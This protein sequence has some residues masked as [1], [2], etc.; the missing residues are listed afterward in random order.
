MSLS[1]A[2]VDVLTSGVPPIP[3]ERYLPWTDLSTD[4]QSQ[5]QSVLSY[6]VR[7]W[8]NPGKNNIEEVAY[9]DLCL[10]TS[11]VAGSSC[12]AVDLLEGIGFTS[13]DTW[14]CWI[15][16]YE[17]FTWDE[18]V[19]MNIAQYY[20]VL[21]W[22]SA[23]WGSENEL[24]HP[25]SELKS[26]DDLS[27]QEQV[28]AANLCF[29]Q[30]LWDEESFS[31]Y[32]VNA[33][34]FE[35]SYTS[36]PTTSPTEDILGPVIDEAMLSYPYK[37]FI[38]FENLDTAT[39]ELVLSLGYSIN[40]WDRPGKYKIET[41]PFDKVCK[42]QEQCDA[43]K[44]LGFTEDS[45]NCWMGHYLEFDWE[46]LVL[47]GKAQYWEVLGWTAT[48]WQL[49]DEDLSQWPLTMSLPYEQLSYD[50][51]VAAANLCYIEP[52]W[53][54]DKLTKWASDYQEISE[55]EI[56][57]EIEAP[58][59]FPTPAPGARGPRTGRGVRGRTSLAAQLGIGGAGATSKGLVN[60]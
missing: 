4:L 42:S 36:S 26:Y 14:D 1:A 8:E 22:N 5:L 48:S 15:G 54:E 6:N 41:T 52:L 32:W 11:G 39:Q 55:P 18:L 31:T 37:R 45:Y 43:L 60:P 10:E 28:A 16:H 33:Y 23:N 27:I 58:S 47:E 24:L 9:N 34:D 30:P 3:V 46:D 21:G 53:D 29:I 19:S 20:E 51:K 13:P 59:N 35:T 17:A 40:Q 50:E 7:R 44:S 49:S 57:A 25:D 38:P 12:D 56:E 2:I